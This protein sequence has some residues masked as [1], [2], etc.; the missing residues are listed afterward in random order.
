MGA[1]IPPA[2][3]ERRACKRL[4]T[5]L[6]IRLALRAGTLGLGPDLAAGLLDVCEDGVGVR[7]KAPLSLDTEA[8]V[9]F[10]KIGSGRPMKLVAD[11]RWCQQDRSGGFRAGLRFRHRMAFRDLMDL[12]RN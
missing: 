8:E 10:E 1:E 4:L 9:V 12:A 3:R 7:L 11:V 5:R 2:V 6:G